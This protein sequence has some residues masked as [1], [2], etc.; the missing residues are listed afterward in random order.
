MDRRREVF[1]Y[2]INQLASR[3]DL[4]LWPGDKCPKKAIRAHSVQNNGVLDALSRSGHVVMPR[5]RTSFDQ[6]PQFVF[7]EVG[8]NKA[9]TFTGLCGEHGYALFEPIEAHPIDLGKKNH[10]FLLAYR[11]VLKEAHAARKSAIDLQLSYQKG[12]EKGLFPKD[13]PSPPLSEREEEH[14]QRCAP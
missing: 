5:L 14:A 9:T 7:R 8:R 11:A 3:L 2:T 10:L 13:E 1:G 4:Y 6:P 12:I